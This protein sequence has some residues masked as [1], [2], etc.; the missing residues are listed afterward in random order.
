MDTTAVSI[1]MCVGEESYSLDSFISEAYDLGVSKRIPKTAIP[2]GI[3]PGLSKLFLAHAK[4]IVKTTRG[5]LKELAYDLF[6]LG[7]IQETA[8]Q[9]LVDLDQ[10]F[11]E[12]DK[13][14][15]GDFVPL[16]MLTI[17]RALSRLK[18]NIHED[19]KEKFGLVYCQGVFGYAPITSIQYVAKAGEDDLPDDLIHLSGYVEPVKVVYKDGE[20]ANS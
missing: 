20:H 8:W 2:E 9:G 16:P 10:P 3:I 15:P 17:T 5:N 7:E 12:N 6:M 19:L 18:E 14:S 4:A 13:L 11:W 1:L